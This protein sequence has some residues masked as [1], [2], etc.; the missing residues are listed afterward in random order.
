MQE[1]LQLMSGDFRI[2]RAQGSSNNRSQQDLVEKQKMQDSRNFPSNHTHL[3][4]L[5]S[6]LEASDS[7]GKTSGNPRFPANHPSKQDYS[8]KSIEKRSSPRKDIPKIKYN[9]ESSKKLKKPSDTLS[10]SVRETR[11]SANSQNRTQTPNQTATS[12]QRNKNPERFDPAIEYT[13]IPDHYVKIQNPQLRKRLENL[14]G[15]LHQNYKC[16]TK[17]FD[18][19]QTRKSGLVFR[20]PMSC[21][22]STLKLALVTLDDDH[23]A[24]DLGV[25][26]MYSTKKNE[27]L[28]RICNQVNA[29][30]GLSFEKKLE[31][32]IQNWI[33]IIEEF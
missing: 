5:S 32:I 23:T 20:A 10:S 9:E 16:A 12:S 24:E 29:Q 17:E 30:A 28:G 7:S 6:S 2:A 21:L 11:S 27:Y 26:M 8:S 13:Y 1:V 3:E 19:N 18:T 4:V 31:F 33:K 14:I 22:T 15:L 25:V